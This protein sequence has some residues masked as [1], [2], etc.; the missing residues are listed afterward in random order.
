MVEIQSLARG[1]KILAI[2]AD[3][4]NGIGITELADQLGVDKSTASRLVH[5]L[6]NNGFVQKARDGRS[7]TLGPMLVNLSRSVITRMPLR[8]SA[9][10]FLKKLVEVSGECSHLAIYAQGKALYVD[11]ME[12]PSTLRVNVEVGQLAPLHCTALGKVMLAFGKYPLPTGLERHTAKTITDLPALEKELETV[13]EKGYAI[14]DE[15]FDN[16]VRCISVPVFDYR[17]K[18]VGAIGISGPSA[19]LSLK[20]IQ[21]LAPQ[22]MQIGKQLSDRL[23]FKRS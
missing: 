4:E 22:I 5:T 7:Y 18:L 15:E 11:Q 14:D 10:P 1:L 21:T 13:R 17:E 12:S 6:L 3:C 8:D 16:D 19:R 23:K 9:Q 20:E 2:M